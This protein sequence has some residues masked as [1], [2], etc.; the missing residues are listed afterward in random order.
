MKH[1]F[2][3]DFIATD[4]R[5]FTVRI[6]HRLKPKFGFPIDADMLLERLAT[7]FTDF[8]AMDTGGSVGF[9]IAKSAQ[10]VGGEVDL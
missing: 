7:K 4:C 5:D 10:V 9:V 3:T 6:G 2:N 8:F 1:G